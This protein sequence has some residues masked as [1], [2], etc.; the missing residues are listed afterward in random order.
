MP[1]E[2]QMTVSAALAK[3]STETPPV[4]HRPDQ[5]GPIDAAVRA[6]AIDP[7]G[8]F[9]V[10]APAGSGKT[11]LLTQRFLALLAQVR[12]PQ[13]VLAI[14]FTRKATRQMVDR[15]LERLWSA[16]RGETPSEDY[17]QRAHELALD[18]L[19][20]DRQRGWNLLQDPGQL[21]IHTID[22][23]CARLA[24][25][26]ALQPFSVAGL[27]VAEY[28]EPLYREAARLAMEDALEAEEGS[29]P[30]AALEA[31][32]ERERG[33]ANQLQDLLAAM[34]PRRDQWLAAALGGGASR[35]G[36]VAARQAIEWDALIGA[37]GEEALLRAG[38]AAMVLAEFT[39]KPIDDDEFPEAWFRARQEGTLDE[40]IVAG[41]LL[42]QRLGG[43]SGLPYKPSS[44]A[45]YVY[46]GSA[47]ETQAAQATLREILE[48]WHESPAALVAYQRFCTS[49]PLDRI[50]GDPELIESLRA[51]L[52]Q[53]VG[54]LNVRFSEQGVCDF[55][56]VAQQALLALGDD[57][58]PGEALL[59]EDRRLEHVL[60]DEFQDTSQ[61]QFEL[62]TR[63]VEG[64]SPDDGRTLFLVGDPMQSIYAFRKA[65]V[66]LFERVLRTGEVGPVTLRPLELTVNFR[67]TSTVVQQVNQTCAPLFAHESAAIPGHV[68]YKP[69][70]AHAGPGGAVVVEA[71]LADADQPAEEEEA[72][73]I[74]RQ[75]L[76]LTGSGEARTVGI[77]ARKRAQ[78]EPIARAL[79]HHGI[80][81]EAVDVESLATRPLVLDLITVTRALLHPGDRVA[82]L[83]LLTAP[84][85]G[86]QPD[87][88]LALAG[89]TNDADVL[90][91]CRDPERLR[92]L[93]AGT[94]GRVERFAQVMA[95]ALEAAVRVPLARRVESAWIGLG[96]ARL[97]RRPEEL[98]D[99]ERFLGLVA[100]LERDLPDD[101][102]TQLEQR[103]LKLYASAQ[104]ADVQ[105]MTIHKAKGLEFDAVFLPGLQGQTGSGDRPLFRQHDMRLDES[106]RGS[107][108]APIKPGGAPEPNL[109]DYLGLLEREAQRNERKRLLYVGMTRAKRHLA[110][111]AV[112][113]RT[114]KGDLTRASG[115]LM[116]LLYDHF[117]AC[118]AELP[119]RETELG[120]TGTDCTRPVP[121]LRLSDAP[122]ALDLPSPVVAPV[123]EPVAVP[124]SWP[125]ERPARERFALGDALH[126]WLELLH[127][128]WHAFSS[129]QWG[130]NGFS[131]GPGQDPQGKPPVPASGDGEGSGDTRQLHAFFRPDNPA[132]RSSLLLA[133][134]PETQVDALVTELAELLH[135]LLAEPEVVALLSGD[136]LRASH[137]EL[138]YLV[139][140]DQRL[141]RQIIDL[142]V[143]DDSGAWRII[144]YKTGREGETS[145]QRWREQ[146]EGYRTIVAA[147]ETGPIE[148]ALVLQAREARFI[149]PG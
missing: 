25:R 4:A 15:I 19:E 126:R 5:V 36:L 145:V 51:L 129:G 6:A 82:W 138:C 13:Q 49:P 58:V 106:E 123:E 64:W 28:P 33:N 50:T 31:L 81:F 85:C 57:Q 35:E 11:E 41:W 115:S 131:Q 73:W 148:A 122:S 76:E 111:T 69:A 27:T 116:N 72:D 124:A 119:E 112:V 54:W 38:D 113:R 59:I 118:Q 127:N 102:V 103:C 114:K 10:Q 9:A 46:P 22:G 23:L 93:D 90:G 98:D 17:L 20:R 67:S 101:F 108:I 117:N 55:Q 16:A 92:A 140:Q 94:R 110:M 1:N 56:H 87:E 43:A 84:W 125:G 44:L 139:P 39:E 14:T 133:G 97:A 146:L 2:D 75:V 88:L 45:R 79:S 68:D 78:L 142:L 121:V 60:I 109:Y 42:L 96:G 47:A 40:W 61:L 18:V 91:H 120:E 141:R 130:G 86:L 48:R 99:V 128:H 37:L 134:A 135:R 107:L 12:E 137:A 147:A 74:A 77:L 7:T 21:Q 3:S 83:G 143:Q 32:L 66:S 149:D 29:A 52:A 89:S 132:L 24:S 8:S 100:S 105:L 30:R 144:D 80:A 70:T 53:A 65:D 136:G 104:P 26:G 34:L 63:L 62:V 71:F 95:G